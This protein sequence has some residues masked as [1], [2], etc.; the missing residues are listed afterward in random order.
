MRTNSAAHPVSLL[1]GRHKSAILLVKWEV[2]IKASNVQQHIESILPL[3][4]FV[5]ILS[6]S[7]PCVGALAPLEHRVIVTT[8]TKCQIETQDGGNFD[9]EDALV[10]RSTG[11]RIHLALQDEDILVT[12]AANN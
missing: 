3:P 12:M 9:I 7:H 5:A 1:L 2:G 10:L 6:E 4:L 11:L 8:V